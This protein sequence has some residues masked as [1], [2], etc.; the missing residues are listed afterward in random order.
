MFMLE[1]FPIRNY[2]LIPAIACDHNGLCYFVAVF[3]FL[4]YL[5]FF[6]SSYNQK[7]YS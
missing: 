6:V 1:N 3:N 5:E 2:F 4:I 7:E